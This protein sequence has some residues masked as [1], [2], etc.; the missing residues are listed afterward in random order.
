MN[1]IQQPAGEGHQQFQLVNSDTVLCTAIYQPS[2][3]TVRISQDQQK[4]NFIFRKKGLLKTKT[5]LENEYG[6]ML[7]NLVPDKNDVNSGIINMEENHFHYSFSAIAGKEITIYEQNNF[8]PFATCGLPSSAAN[9]KHSAQ[10]M[11]MTFCWYLEFAQ[12]LDIKKTKPVIAHPTL[13]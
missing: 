8:T 3:G 4:R 1:W 9:D 6:V 7:A 12:L 10:L 5:L 13:H 2:A 11:L